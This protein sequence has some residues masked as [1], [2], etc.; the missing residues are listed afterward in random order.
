M[1]RILLFF[2]L[3]L[4]FTAM[5]AV[6]ATAQDC[7][8]PPAR[9]VSW[10]PGDGDANDIQDSNDGMPQNGVAFGAGMV[11]QAFLFDGID[12]FVDAGNAGN[13]HVSSGDFTVDAWVLFHSLTRPPVFPP[14]RL[15]DMSLADK[16]NPSGV[17]T[18]GWRLLKQDDNRFWFCLGP[19]TIDGCI[20]GGPL[21]VQS[22]TVVTT[23]TLN[24]WFHIAAVKAG[25]TIS[26]YV[27]GVQEAT[28]TLGTSFTDT[29]TANLLLGTNALEGAFLQGQLDEVEI[30]NRAL[31]ALEIQAIFDASSAGK[32]KPPTIEDLLQ[33][34]EDLED[35]THTYRTGIGEGHNNAEADTGEA[36][37]QED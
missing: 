27:N 23:A 29:N 25:N 24:T 19:G 13:L 33:R 9:L 21:T 34:I 37:V 20:P 26:L 32:C 5:L 2:S 3:T 18:D 6:P 7:V 14:V 28:K 30:F 4:F 12:D 22:T 8:E 10:W 36:E 16:M 11:D 17:N 15:G 1:K 31:S 35:H